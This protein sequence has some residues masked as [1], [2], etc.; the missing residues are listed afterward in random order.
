MFPT[1]L[2]LVHRSVAL[3][4]NGLSMACWA[5]ALDQTMPGPALVKLF[6]ELNSIELEISKMD[7][8]NLKNFL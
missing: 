7:K 6:F 8:S 2:Y 4:S 1:A 3:C 5:L